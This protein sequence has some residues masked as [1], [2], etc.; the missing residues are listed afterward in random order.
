[1]MISVIT[2]P[3]EEP[4]VPA[5]VHAHCSIDDDADDLLLETY[6]ASA[7]AVAEETTGRQL[8]TATKEVILDGFP[9]DDQIRIPSPPLIELLSVKYLDTNGVEQTLDPSYYVVEKVKGEAGLCSFLRLGYGLVWPSVQTVRRNV[10]VRFRCGYVTGAGTELDPEVAHV[11]KGILHAMM[12]GVEESYGNRGESIQ[13]R[14]STAATM[15]MTRL[16]RRFVVE[17]MWE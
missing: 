6:I 9:G 1:M 15:T 12:V 2:E 4:L 13:G 10:R 5:D 7:R 14:I 17:D 8:M 11:P 16:L 3:T